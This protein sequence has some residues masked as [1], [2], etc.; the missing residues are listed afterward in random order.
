MTQDV[1]QEVADLIW[2]GRQDAAVATATAAL[3]DADAPAL[4]VAQ[5][6]RLLV[7]RSQS[8]GLKGE[9]P[10]ATGDAQAAWVLADRARSDALRAHACVALVTMQ[11]REGQLTQA[12]ATAQRGL[13]ATKPKAS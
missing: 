13:R 2:A 12:E 7:L 9:W 5:R 4:T 8:Q 11:V 3:A 1:V 10:Q 6:V